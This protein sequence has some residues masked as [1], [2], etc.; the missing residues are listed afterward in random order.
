VSLSGRYSR[1]SGLIKLMVELF[2]NWLDF[3]WIPVILVFLKKGQK[4]KATLF[5]LVC[6]LVLRLEVELIKEIGY[7]HGFFPFLASPALYRGYMVY[8]I[9]I[10]FFLLMGRISNES[11]VFVYM[12]AGISILVLASIVSIGV[13][14][15]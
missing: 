14:F 7:E 8:G 5:V 1:V 9:F 12:A 15:L 11:N 2:L 13:M 3:L 6:M 10:G 4:L